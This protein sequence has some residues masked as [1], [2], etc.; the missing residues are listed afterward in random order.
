MGLQTGGPPLGFGDRAFRSASVRAGEGGHC[1]TRA[2]PPK[3]GAFVRDFKD[4]AF[5]MAEERWSVARGREELN[6]FGR[7]LQAGKSDNCDAGSD[8]IGKSHSLD[9]EGGVT[10]RRP[11]RDKQHLVFVMVDDRLQGGF[12]LSQ[13]HV[14]QGAF[15][16]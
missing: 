3:S 12:G 9:D 16:N 11:E 14:I 5:P 2:A 13:A 7:G 8:F 15:K 4:R 10:G 6:P 1:R